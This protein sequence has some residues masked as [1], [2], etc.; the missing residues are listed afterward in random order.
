MRGGAYDVIVVSAGP[1]G[2]TCAGLLAKAG[3][4]TLLVDKNDRAGGKALT[5][6]SKGFTY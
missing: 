3:L 2:A 1:G 4:R 6:S 5:L